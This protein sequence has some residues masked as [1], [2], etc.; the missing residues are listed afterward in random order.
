MYF[1]IEIVSNQNPK[2]QE[3]FT[4]KFAILNLNKIEFG[5]F[6]LSLFTANTLENIPNNKKKKKKMLI[7]RKANIYKLLP[8][9]LTT[10]GAVTKYI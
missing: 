2:M 8:T 10:A 1:I 9:A 7:I 4:C 5:E 6:K 3:Y